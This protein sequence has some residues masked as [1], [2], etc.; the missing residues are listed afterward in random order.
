MRN[1]PVAFSGGKAWDPHTSGAY[2][3]RKFRRL[4]SWPSSDAEVIAAHRA[5]E[6][7]SAEP[8]HLLSAKL[9]LCRSVSEVWSRGPWFLL[10]TWAH[11][12]LG[13]KSKKPE[14][15]RQRR[16]SLDSC[17]LGAQHQP[18]N[19]SAPEQISSILSKPV[20]WEQPRVLCLMQMVFI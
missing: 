12:W 8:F 14:H 18:W 20:F 1:L 19:S 9:T 3:Q 2:N 16:R 4:H 5:N 6:Q 10:C 7:N 17:D 13:L 11:R 15:S